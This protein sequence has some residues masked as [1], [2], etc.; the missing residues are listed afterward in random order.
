[1]ALHEKPKLCSPQKATDYGGEEEKAALQQQLRHSQLRQVVWTGNDSCLEAAATTLLA[2][3]DSLDRKRK[4]SG[5][6]SYNTLRL[7]PVVLPE[8]KAVWQQQL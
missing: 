3:A 8:T 5:N 4:L 2:T 6:S 1:M 7:R